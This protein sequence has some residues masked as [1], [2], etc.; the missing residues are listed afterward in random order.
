[1]HIKTLKIDYLK[2]RCYDFICFST[3]G[4]WTLG[5]LTSGVMYPL[6]RRACTAKHSNP[7]TGSDHST[8]KLMCPVNH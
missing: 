8:F 3:L 2:I 1:M 4:V 5:V 6:P 7:G